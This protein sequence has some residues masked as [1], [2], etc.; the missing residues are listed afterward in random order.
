MYYPKELVV[1]GQWHPQ[2]ALANNQ[3]TGADLFRNGKAFF[4]VASPKYRRLAPEKD[5]TER[6]DIRDNQEAII[7]ELNEADDDYLKGKGEIFN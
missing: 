3:T 1:I 7:A 5:S 6:K 4:D 2:T